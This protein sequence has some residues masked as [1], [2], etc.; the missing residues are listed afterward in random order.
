MGS[1]VSQGAPCGVESVKAVSDVIAPLSGEVLSEPEGGRRAG[2][3]Q[4]G[5]VRRGLAHPD[6]P[7]R[8]G[9]ADALMDAAAYGSR[10]GA[11]S[12]R[13]QRLP[14]SDRRRP[15]G[16]ARGDRRLLGGRAFEQVLRAYASTAFDLRRRSGRPSSRAT[17]RSS[18]RG[19]STR[20]RSSRSSGRGSTTTTS[21]QWRTSCSRGASSDRATP[22]QPEIARACCRRSS[23]TRRS[24]A[25]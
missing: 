1:T 7:V 14:L 16:D 15:R 4:R 12:E 24:S 11:V 9:R 18:R 10:R 5:P 23:S 6:P 2:G 3:R 8:R 17:S 25:S 19:T 21:R 22:Y 13:W 20:A